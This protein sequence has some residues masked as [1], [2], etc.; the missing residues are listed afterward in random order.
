MTR[1]NEAE[2]VVALPT[3]IQATRDSG[4]K[5][6]AFALA[7]L[8]DNSIEAQAEHISILIKNRPQREVVVTDDG[9]GMRPKVLKRSLQFGGSSKFNA[10]DGMGRYG[11]GL[12]NASLSQARRVEVITWQNPRYQYFSYLDID[13]VV[14]GALNHLVQPSRI[15]SHNYQPE[16]NSGTAVFWKK[17]D[18]ITQKYLGVLEKK[19]HEELGRIFRYYLWQGVTITVNGKVVKPI[20]PLFLKAGNNLIGGEPFGKSLT[21]TV[22][23]PHGGSFATSVVSVRFIELPVDQWAPLSNKAKQ[24]FR[25]SKKSGVSI[26]R[27]DREIDYGWFFMGDKRRE[28]YDDW[29][30]CEVRFLPEVDEIFGVTHTKQDIHPTEYLKKILTPDIESI[31]KRL[32]QRVREKFQSYKA[33]SIN[34]YAK[35]LVEDTDRYLP[36]PVPSQATSGQVPVTLQPSLLH[37]DGPINGLQ[38]IFNSQRLQEDDFFSTRYSLEEIFITLNQEHPFFDLVYQAIKNDQLEVNDIM[39]RLEMIIFAAARVETLATT[40]SEQEAV[41]WFK[42]KWSDVLASYLS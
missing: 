28:N 32:N 41:K 26:I 18:R 34:S 36:P 35:P 7:E 29:W 20:D 12:P 6:T 22:R 17:C 15:S 31:A 21:Y 10:R 3:F 33:S 13:E 2:T 14:D 37:R 4:Y 8:V 30:R 27:S 38:Y 9:I 40:E 24:R 25:I 1:Y 5:N 42:A 39:Q 23:N 19:L 11:M 16:S